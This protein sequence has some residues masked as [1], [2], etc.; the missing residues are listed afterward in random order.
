[1][2]AVFP[3]NCKSIEVSFHDDRTVKDNPTAAVPPL[4]GQRR[5]VAVFI[6]VAGVRAK[7]LCTT[8]ALPSATIAPA[9][10]A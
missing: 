2:K 7:S 6:P 4:T 3:F 9:A 10:A 5:V 1:M 8:I